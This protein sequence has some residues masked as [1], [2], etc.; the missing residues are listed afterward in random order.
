M[1]LTFFSYDIIPLEMAFHGIQRSA[2]WISS[3][4]FGKIQNVKY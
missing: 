2:E 4:M 1:T 3:L